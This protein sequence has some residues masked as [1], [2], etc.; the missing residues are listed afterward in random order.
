[1]KGL[2]CTVDRYY[3]AGQ[4]HMQT[5][6]TTGS[7]A[8]RQDPVICTG[9][10]PHPC[11]VGTGAGLSRQRVW[12][13]FGLLRKERQPTAAYMTYFIRK[14]CGT[15][16]SVRP[17][18]FIYLF[19]L[20]K[21]RSF[22]KYH[23]SAINHWRPPQKKFDPAGTTVNFTG[24]NP[25]HF[26]NSLSCFLCFSWG[27][28]EIYDKMFYNWPRPLLFTFLPVTCSVSAN[29]LTLYG[30]SYWQRR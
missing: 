17:F 7:L 30:I 5:S 25:G 16:Q 2:I 29:H 28:L 21:L 11:H 22:T 19:P 24:E 27:P 18:I 15:T 4:K 26:T 6:G 20:I 8:D 1:M 13:T 3:P 23:T 9:P 10:P 12:T 14:T